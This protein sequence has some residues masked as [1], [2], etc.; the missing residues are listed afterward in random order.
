MNEPTTAQSAAATAKILTLAAGVDLSSPGVRDDALTT[1]EGGG[2]VLLSGTGFELTASEAALVGHLGAMLTNEP[3]VPD[4]RPTII[5]DPARGGIK[6]YHFAYSRGK[7]VRAQL[8]PSARP[9]IEAMMSRFGGWAEGLI[10]RLLPRYGTTLGRDRITYRPN[11]RG[12]VQPLH[13]DSSYGFPTQ[14]RGMLRVFCNID[15][16]NRPRVW[17]VGEPFAPV[18]G[19][20][21]A[22][23][24]PQR[25]GLGSAL[26]AR[27]GL[28]GGAQTAYDQMMADLRRLVKGDKQY[29]RE[30]PRRIVEFPTG[31]TWIALTDLVLHGAVSGQHSLD[32]TFYLPAAAMRDPAQSSLHMLEQM[33]GQRLV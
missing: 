8:R 22:A 10:G 18:A 2:I 21:V 31:S 16:A 28:L 4:G 20:Y 24:R 19:R 32:Q 33:T 11:P 15:P 3:Q 12:D 7:L 14:G 26:L 23:L 30:A 27:L 6:R 9:V 1:L 25:P 29:Q 13:M 5:F 17:Q